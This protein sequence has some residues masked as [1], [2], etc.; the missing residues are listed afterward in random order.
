MLGDL[1]HGVFVK[2]EPLQI[3]EVAVEVQ[4]FVSSM[5]KLGRVIRVCSDKS[6][7]LCHSLYS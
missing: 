1:D 3:V 4:M 6:A 2:V 5:L 7:R